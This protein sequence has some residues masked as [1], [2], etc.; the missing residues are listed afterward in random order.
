MRVRQSRRTLGGCLCPLAPRCSPAS[1][2][3]SAT[4]ARAGSL[5]APWARGT[6]LQGGKTF[7]LKVCF[8]LA[9]PVLPR[10]SGCRRA[11]VAALRCCLWLLFWCPSQH[12]HKRLPEQS[13]AGSCFRGRQVSA[14][15]LSQPQCFILQKTMFL[16]AFEA[17]A[18]LAQSLRGCF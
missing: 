7:W 18:A 5:L 9:A 2:R 4:A 11:R 17:G 8:P 13:H 12:L 14:L 10:L 15:F 1:R 6:K 16:G 3:D